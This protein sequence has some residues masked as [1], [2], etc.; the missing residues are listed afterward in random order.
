[1]NT[2]SSE[3][4]ANMAGEVFFTSLLYTMLCTL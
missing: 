1:M 2:T 4:T 3:M